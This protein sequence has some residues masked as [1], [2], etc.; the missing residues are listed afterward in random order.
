MSIRN[1]EF[2]L[3]GIYKR[4][5]RHIFFAAIDKIAYLKIDLTDVLQGFIYRVPWLFPY[6]TLSQ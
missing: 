4:K 2:R 5:I 1:S 6:K 3:I